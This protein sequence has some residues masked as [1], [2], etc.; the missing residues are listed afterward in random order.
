ML[1]DQRIVASVDFRFEKPTESGKDN[2]G[3]YDNISS[4]YIIQRFLLQ[5]NGNYKLVS[6]GSSDG[7]AYF[8]YMKAYDLK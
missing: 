8:I 3:K 4:Q 6:Y 7:K 1:K 2:K 5:K